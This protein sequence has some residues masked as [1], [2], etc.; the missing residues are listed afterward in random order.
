M[1]IVESVEATTGSDVENDVTL[2]ATKP[3]LNHSVGARSFDMMD[4]I[5]DQLRRDINDDRS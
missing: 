2:V 3:R 5:D 4:H 1:R